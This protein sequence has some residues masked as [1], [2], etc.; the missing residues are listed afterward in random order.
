[1]DWTYAVDKG[2]LWHVR[3]GTY[4]FFSVMEVEVREYLHINTTQKKTE[5]V[6]ESVINAITTIEDMLFH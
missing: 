1:M 6:K 5:E 4:M 2:G 3:K